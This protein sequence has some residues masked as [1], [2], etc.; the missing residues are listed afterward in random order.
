MM[1]EKE[2]TNLD[3][4]LEAVLPQKAGQP[5]K[6]VK[7]AAAKPKAKTTK[8]R[9]LVNSKARRK[10]AVARATIKPG[11]GTVKINGI[12]VSLLE[13]KEVRELILEPIRI[14]DAAGDIARN[15]D[16][17]INVQGGGVSG[18]AQAARAALAKAITYTNE[19]LR[20]VFKEYDR[21][22]LVDDYRQ[23]EPK[24]FKGPKARAR[25]QKSYR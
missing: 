5:K 17:S 11:K 22:M 20:P 12:D 9:K 3:K 21:N 23:V 15:S 24:K 10:A 16:I 4:E 1:A 14:S 6:E 8:A 13:P 19:S 7:K 25:F 18:Q 2:L